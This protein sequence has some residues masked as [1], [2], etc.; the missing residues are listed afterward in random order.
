MT[1][2]LTRPCL[3]CGGPIPSG[4]YCAACRPTRKRLSATARGYPAWWA[5]LSA[6]ARSWQP[7]CTDCLTTGTSENPLTLDHSPEAWRLTEQGKRLTL[8]HV[9]AG[10][11]TVVCAGCNRKRGAARGQHVS[12][13]YA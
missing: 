4:T 9:A 6:E 2:G 11:L 12:R 1:A 10:L 7:F 8:R 5:K 3:G 13:R